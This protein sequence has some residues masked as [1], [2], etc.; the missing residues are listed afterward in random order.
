[1]APMSVLRVVLL[2]T[3]SVLLTVVLGFGLPALLNGAMR[4]FG[5]PET[6]VTECIVLLY[7][8]FVLYVAMPR[9][10]R[11]LVEVMLQHGVLFQLFL[12]NVM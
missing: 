9:I 1:M 4:M 11:G 8:L 7:V 3:F 2:V 10:P 5:L 12:F 6:S